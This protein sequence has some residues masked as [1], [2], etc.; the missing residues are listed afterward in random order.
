[1]FQDIHPH[2]INMGYTESAPAEDDWIV[3][4]NGNRLWMVA[5][6]GEMRFP[7]LDEAKKLLPGG[8]GRLVHLFSVDGKAVRLVLDAAPEAPD[9]VAMDMNRFRNMNPPWMAFT[10]VTAGHLGMWYLANKFCGACGNPMQLKKDERAVEC[11]SCGQIVYPRISPAVI[12]GVVNGDKI[13]L[14]RYNRPESRLTA[15]IAGF[16]EVGET[17][18][19]TVRREVREEVGLEVAR[20]RY[21]KSQPWAFSGSVL[22]G[23]YADLDGAPELTVDKTELSEAKWL[24]RNELPDNMDTFSLTAEMVDTFRR[25]MHPA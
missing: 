25:G 24:A 2:N 13:L 22:A 21:Y 7:R 20:I 14:T 1:M 6:D 8:D 10:G 16:M 4:L 17:F 9:L 12:T 15:L 5:D 18:E 19:D 23:F 3:L 11:G